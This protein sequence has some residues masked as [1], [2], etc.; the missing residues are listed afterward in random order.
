LVDETKLWFWLSRRRLCKSG[1]GTAMQKWVRHEMHLLHL[2]GLLQSHSLPKGTS[3]AITP[4]EGF[5]LRKNLSKWV[6]CSNTC[7][8]HA[9]R[10]L[11]SFEL[12]NSRYCP[13]HNKLLVTGFVS[14]PILDS[15]HRI[16]G[17]IQWVHLVPHPFLHS[18]RRRYV[19]WSKSE[20]PARSVVTPFTFGKVIFPFYSTNSCPRR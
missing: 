15:R 2:C 20:F 17:S 1:W 19:P 11:S 10:L 6:T 8:A 7:S 3:W 13:Q 9:F 16:Y 12:S 14:H 5:L 18:R 4:G